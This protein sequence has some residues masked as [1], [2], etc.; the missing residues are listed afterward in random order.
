MTPGPGSRRDRHQRHRA[1]L[2]LVVKG[3]RGTFT[4]GDQV[5]HGSYALDESASPR[6]INITIADGPDKGK[7]K[8]GIY[9]V[10]DNVLRLCV[11]PVGGK[12]PARFESTAGRP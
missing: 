10:K 4:R 8:L 6:S 2:R 9:E 11:G 5:T 1:A 12:R 7:K 3:D